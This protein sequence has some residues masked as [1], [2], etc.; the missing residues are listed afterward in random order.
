[1]KKLTFLSMLLL[2]GTVGYGDYRIVWHTIDG[3][4]G[5]ISGGAYTLTNTIGQPDAGFSAAG[6]YE[7]LGGFWAGGPACFVTLEDFAHFARYWL[8]GPCGAD[9]DWCGGADLDTSG[10]VS[11]A[12]FALFCDAWLTHCPY[13]WRLK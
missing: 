9:N 6:K 5:T 8:D 4:G 10:S 1:M 13:A 12:D 2:F 3:G 11:I 7:V